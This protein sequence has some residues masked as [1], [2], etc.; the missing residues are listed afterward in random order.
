M[1]TLFYKGPSMNPTLR[2][3][4]VL[5]VEPCPSGCAR[6]G[7]VIVYADPNGRGNVVHRV[8]S[9]RCDGWV[10]TQGDGNDFMDAY[11]VPGSAIL[12]RVTHVTRNG[13]RHVVYGGP[14]GRIVGVSARLYR[15]VSRRLV[16]SLRPVYASCSGCLAFPWLLKRMNFRIIQYSRC[17]RPSELH[18]FMGNRCIGRLL[19][20]QTGWRITPPFKLLV[21]EKTLPHD[22]PSD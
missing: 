9:V 8:M 3:P 18:L 17:G 2:A 15:V 5:H 21:D 1:R 14:C 12:G 13:K 7:D 16:R 20:H 22:I 19:P 4:D 6:P 11:V 10:C